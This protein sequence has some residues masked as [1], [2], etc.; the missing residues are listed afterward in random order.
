MDILRRNLVKR[1][2]LA[3]AVAVSWLLSA[4][5]ALA[6]GHGQADSDPESNLPFLY[7]FAVY[8]ITWVAFFGYAVYMTRRQRALGRQIEDLRHDIEDA[9]G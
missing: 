4:G 9:R 7:L 2:T 5:A 1:L 8:S 6:A 3:F